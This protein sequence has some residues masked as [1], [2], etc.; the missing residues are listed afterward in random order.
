MSRR[1]PARTPAGPR[2]TTGSPEHATLLRVLMMAIALCLASGA[3]LVDS[4]VSGGAAAT[5]SGGGCAS[6]AG[7]RSIG[8]SAVDT[9]HRRG[10]GATAPLVAATRGVDV[11]HWDGAASMASVTRSGAAFVYAKA[12][13]GRG[14]VDG[15]FAARI[16][17][18][19]A[20]GLLSGAY[21][22]F[23]YR[24]DG[25]A[26]AR[27]FVATVR[28]HGGFAGHLPP[29]VDVECLRALGRSSPGYAARQLRAFLVEVYRRTGRMAVIYTSPYM[30]HQ[31]TGN[32]GSFG[33]YPLWVACWY[34]AH[35]TL[36]RGWTTWTLWQVGKV[37]I[38]GVR[39]DGDIFRG[40]RTTLRRSRT[41]TPRIA[42]GTR[43]VTTDVRAHEPPR[44]GR[45]V[46]PEQHR[47]PPLDA[48]AAIHRG[49][50]LPAPCPGRPP[51]SVPPVP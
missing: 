6:T 12:T 16:H 23:D 21:H 10:S 43:Y 15:T 31:V 20:A 29:A 3:S 25:I 7:V 37:G 36:P 26:Q 1:V 34:C 47:W 17:A 51:A 32:D 33:A 2:R 50:D 45:S 38:A 44:P 49:R 8:L 42:G 46:V 13:Q 28:R 9:L 40:G 19:A 27:F 35:P 5:A 24:T 41:T 30:W 48:L 39:V 11:S 4:L 14:I 22:F 18:A